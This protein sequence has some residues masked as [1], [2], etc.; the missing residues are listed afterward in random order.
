M[1]KMEQK[2]NQ[3]KLKKLFSFEWKEDIF[4]I[5][6][7]LLLFA[8]AY[9]YKLD[10][11]ICKPYIEDPCGICENQSIQQPRMRETYSDTPLN[12][13]FNFTENE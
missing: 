2:D 1:N 6:F 13:S 12:I 7:F 9:A 11:K 10:M 4:W 8:S 3:D 5:V